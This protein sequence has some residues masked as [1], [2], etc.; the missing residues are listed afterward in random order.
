[1]PHNG[2]QKIKQTGWHG[3]M[4]RRS[5]HQISH[6]LNKRIFFLLQRQQIED[7]IQKRQEALRIEVKRR[8]A[9]A[10]EVSESHFM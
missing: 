5:S 9:E 7:E 2:V 4:L 3:L 1:M 6:P 8:R 10:K